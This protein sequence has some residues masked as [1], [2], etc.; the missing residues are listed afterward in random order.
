[1]ANPILNNNFAQQERVLESEPMTVNGT[2]QITA[3]LGLL[4]VA[5]ASFVWQKY[6]QGFTDLALMLT[7]AGVIVGFISALIVAFSR[8][9]ILVPGLLDHQI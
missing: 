2:I 8:N 6:T 7:G 3:F 9:K 4:L 1:M 5:A